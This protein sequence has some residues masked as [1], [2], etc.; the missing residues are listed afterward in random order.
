MMKNWMT[1][2][3]ATCLLASC[4]TATQKQKDELIGNWI[5]VMPVNLQ[6]VQGVTLNA[7]RTAASIGMATLKYESWDLTENK[8]ILNGKSIGNG[9]TIDFSD[10]LDIVTLTPD[11]LKVGKYG[12][13]RRDYYRVTEI[14]AAPKKN[15][16]L[17]SLQKTDGTGELQTR[18]FEGT[19]PAASCPG[20]VYNITIYNYENSGDGVFKA[21]LTYL[22]AENGQDKT[23]EFSGRQYTLR[24]HATNK[25]A[26]VFQFVPF[27]K[28]QETMN[29]IFEE[30][31]LT[32]LDR[33][34]KPIESKLNYT[35]LLQ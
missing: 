29:F 4:H 7:D 26:T 31:K 8:L 23:Y 11:S 10:T 9:Q 35:L 15:S 18:I 1:L 14:P 24:G 30:N 19:L 33:E 12:A 13:Y 22:E 6:F 27:D 3:A 21:S 2:V 25:D 16:L 34:M 20:I 28:N 5:E 17:D 32:M